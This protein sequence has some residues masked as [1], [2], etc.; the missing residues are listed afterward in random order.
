MILDDL[1]EL[2]QESIS[3]GI[4]IVGRIKGKFLLEQV[5]KLK[6]KKILELGTANGYSGTILGSEGATLTTIEIDNR[7]V[8]EANENFKKF[9]IKAEIILGDG[10]K[11]IK[12][13]KD[14]TFDMVFV[15]FVKNEYLTVLE[16]CIRV[17][18]DKAVIIADN[19]TFEGCQDFR[20]AVLNHPNLKTK[21]ID[22]AD[23][24]S[25]SIINK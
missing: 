4:P 25:F 18:K 21:I 24:M 23:G 5:K 6:P 8:E 17:A 13:F 3:R 10:V 15:D 16:D 2:E 19:I 12:K 22:L 20:E 9:H 7:I 14:N 1:T 11:E